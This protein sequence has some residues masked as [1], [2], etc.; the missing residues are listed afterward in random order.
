[1]EFVDIWVNR[2]AIGHAYMQDDQL[3]GALTLRGNRRTRLD[4]C[5]RCPHERTV[6]A[7][8]HR[9][10]RDEH[11]PIVYCVDCFAI[12]AGLDP[13]V[14]ARRPRWKHDERNAVITRWT[15][16]WPKRGRPALRRAS[17]AD[18]LARRRLGEELA[19]ARERCE[20]P[21][22][23]VLDVVEVK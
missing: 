10:S 11:W 14:H 9:R 20:E 8:A 5:E 18:R 19:M 1:M 6:E 16:A 12:T 21:V 4:A 3:E 15:R 17:T 13:L 7:F 2:R 23:I 22:D